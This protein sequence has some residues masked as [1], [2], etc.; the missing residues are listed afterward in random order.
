MKNLISEQK[1]EIYTK[2]LLRIE[3]ATDLSYTA[4]DLSYYWLY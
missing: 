1:A 2:F 4:T 3:A